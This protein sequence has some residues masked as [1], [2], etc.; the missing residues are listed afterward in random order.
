MSEFTDEQLVDFV[1]GL[2]AG[3]GLEDA[4][5]AQPELQR[6]CSAVKS[7]LCRLEEEL[8]ELVATGPHDVLAKASWRILLAVDRSAG[9]RR[10]ALAA[11]A[12]ALRSDGVIEVLHVCRSGLWGW[13]GVVAGEKRAE[14]AALIT[15][16]LSEVRSHGVMTRGQLRHAPAG[17]LATNILR[18]AEEIAADVI[19][20]GSRPRSRLSTLWAPGVAATVVRRA[21]C[22]VLVA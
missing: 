13:V 9:A 12:L 1:L 3:D 6:R 19:V 16:V 2:G 11:I 21:G 10:A 20:I 8:E 15:P 4:V 5:R 7:D 17:L 18:E 14:G 22:P